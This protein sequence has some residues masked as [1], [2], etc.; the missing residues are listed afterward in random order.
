MKHAQ[1]PWVD[2]S[3]SPEGITVRCERCGAV[4]HVATPQQANQVA[5]QHRQHGLGDVVAAATKAVG[6]KPCTPCEARQRALNGWF[7]KIWGR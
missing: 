5:L 7:P 1:V 6:I 2:A 3:Q 4:A